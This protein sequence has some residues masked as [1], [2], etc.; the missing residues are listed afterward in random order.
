MQTAPR[1]GAYLLNGH[2]LVKNMSTKNDLLIP[3]AIEPFARRKE[4]KKSVLI[5]E[6]I[7]LHMHVTAFGFQLFI[8][9][10]LIVFLFLLLVSCVMA[11]RE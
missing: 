9:F 8:C 10:I 6:G 2:V 7:W 4:R 1:D 3:W 5:L 11:A